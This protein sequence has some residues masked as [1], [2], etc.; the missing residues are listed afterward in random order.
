MTAIEWFFLGW[1][2][3]MLTGGVA[4]VFAT[5]RTLRW[6][7]RCQDRMARWLTFGL[8]RKAIGPIMSDETAIRVSFWMGVVMTVVGTGTLTYLAIRWLTA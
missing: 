6:T 3:F 8:M 5:E 1:G 2:L 4:Y 7:Y